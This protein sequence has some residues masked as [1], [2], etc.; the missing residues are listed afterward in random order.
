MAGSESC[1]SAQQ[2]PGHAS[3]GRTCRCRCGAAAALI[4]VLHKPLAAASSCLLGP[5]PA[6][7]GR[8]LGRICGGTAYTAARAVGSLSACIAPSN[9]RVAG[10]P[11]FDALACAAVQQLRSDAD[12]DCAPALAAVWCCFGTLICMRKA[13]FVE[14]CVVGHTVT[15]SG[16]IGV[17]PWVC[18]GCCLGMHD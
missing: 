3:I 2:M 4:Q 15:A 9:D 1:T 16:I 11:R 17:Q 7:V 14:A 5:L 6:C 12:G 18:C 13:V 10:L 8:I